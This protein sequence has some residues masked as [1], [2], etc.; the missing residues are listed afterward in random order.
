MWGIPKGGLNLD[1]SPLDAAIRETSE[2][3]GFK[4]TAEQ[5]TTDPIIFNYNDKK[6]K[7]YKVV[8]CYVLN[9]DN[10]PHFVKDN[11]W[12][13]EMLQIEEVDKAA[14]YTAEEAE[15]KIFWRMKNLLTLLK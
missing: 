8:Y 3:I 14:F 1:E 9:L 10:I 7:K 6:G 11:I 2:E 13:S 5:L 12:P 4:V 15:K